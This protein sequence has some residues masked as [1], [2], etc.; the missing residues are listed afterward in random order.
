MDHC[1]QYNV[2]G[3]GIYIF[4]CKHQP[5]FTCVCVYHLNKS[6]QYSGSSSNLHSVEVSRYG[7]HL[8]SH[9]SA[10]VNKEIW[11]GG[12]SLCHT[13]NHNTEDGKCAYANTNT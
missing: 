10:I 1:I 7:I 5:V 2:V 12:Q 11:I 4:V 6:S 3:Y 13:A 8:L 9:I